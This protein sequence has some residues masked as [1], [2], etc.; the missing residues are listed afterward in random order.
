MALRAKLTA[1]ATS[2]VL[3]ACSVVGV[4]GTEEP[5][6]QVVDRIGTVEIRQYGPRVAAETAVPGDELA[7]RS[8]GFRRLAAYIF[9]AN[10]ARSA[11][12]MTAPVAQERPETIAMTAPVAQNRDDTGQ[13]VIRFYMPAQYTLQTVPQPLDP[14]VRLVAVPGETVA[15]LRFSGS[16]GPEAVAARQRELL[17]ALQG[18][19]WRPDGSVAAWFYDPPWTLPPFRR[20]EVAVPVAPADRR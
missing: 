5:R 17:A 3:A 11:I 8:A 6:H 13:W 20:N 15:V 14:S 10:R 4:R 9:G 12:A 1:V 18:A 16:I 2:T 7:A 19:A